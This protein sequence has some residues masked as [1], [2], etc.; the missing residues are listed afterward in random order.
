MIH[1]NPYIYKFF[2]QQLNTQNEGELKNFLSNYRL[3]HIDVNVP[4][5]VIRIVSE[6]SINVE[7]LQTKAKEKNWIFETIEHPL[8]ELQKMSVTIEGMTCRSCEIVIER[9]WKDIPNIKKVVVSASTGKA[10][11]N[12]EGNAPTVSELQLA[13]GDTHYRVVNTPLAKNEQHTSDEKPT[14]W[15]ILGLFALVLLISTVLSRLGLFKA[16]LTVNQA[17]SFAAVFLVGLLAASSSCIAVVGGLLLSSAA[18]FNEKYSEAT[19]IKKM[20]PVA[21]FVIGR[22]SSYTLLGGLLGIVGEVL[23]PSPLVTA[24]ITGLAALYML[25][26]GLQMLHIAPQWLRRLLPGSSKLLSHKIIEAEEKRH[27]FMPFLLGAA[28]FFLP[29]GFTQALQLYALTTGSFTAGATTLLAFALGTAPALLALGFASG[30][31]KGKVGKWFFQFSG[32]LV[33]VLG[34]WNIQ[35]ALSLAGYP[36][37][38]SSLA[39]NQD[40]AV[41]I[42]AESST[43]DKEVQIIKMN[44]DPYEGYTPNNFTLEVGRPVRWEIDGTNAGGCASVLVSRKFGIQKVLKPGINTIT[45]TPKE[46]GTFA[47]SC[48]MG[49]YRGTFQVLPTQS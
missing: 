22:I 5:Q 21:L 27:P 28:T 35:N 18:K 36:I 9:Q 12:Y 34:L 42:S 20:K 44:V 7:E 16:N 48:S 25:I 10:K 45:F 13:L 11:I 37:S 47:F 30:S 40:S 24:L 49:M 26:M 43:G 29:C 33:I 14:I 1:P 19:R 6:Y 32:A 23:S 2:I 15:R 4:K 3:L 46:S 38:L 41:E 8:T 39:S 17:S 31:L